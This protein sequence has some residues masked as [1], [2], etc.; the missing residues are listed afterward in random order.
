MPVVEPESVVMERFPVYVQE[1]LEYYV[2][3]LIDPRNGS[4]FYIG[5]GKG[6]RVF[7]H[8]ALATNSPD[9]KKGEIPCADRIREIR[10]VNLEPTHIIHRHGMSEKEA[11]EVEAALIDAFDGQLTNIATGQG[12]QDR[13]PAHVQQLI[14]KYGPEVIEFGP[15]D[16]IIVIKIKLET[17]RQLGTYQA[18]RASWKVSLSRAQRAESILA[19]VNGICRGVYVECKWCKSKEHPGPSPRYE[20]DGFEAPEEIADKYLGKRLP[21]KMT[22]KGVANPI[23]YTYK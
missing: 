8:A 22:Q 6:N 11:F 23:R 13:G 16:K 1:K 12:S 20:F 7:S 3:R 9:F 18:V 14:E 15:E 10:S 2:Y 19:A 4:T 17:Q 5:K 21:D